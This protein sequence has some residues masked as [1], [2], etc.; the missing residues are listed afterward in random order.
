MK[1]F[2]K[3]I[4]VGIITWEAKVILAKY[5]PKT[6][7]VI[8]SVGKTTAKNAIHSA[9]SGSFFVRKT[10]KSIS[11]DMGVPLAVLGLRFGG[12]NPFRWT[13]NII[14][15]FFMI[16]IKVRYPQWLILEVGG[17]RPGDVSSIARWLSP[18][19]VVITRLGDI[20][21]HVEYFPSPE[22]LI[23]EKA[24][25][26][27]SLKPEGM[28]VLNR[29]DRRV[30]E[31][32]DSFINAKRT[33]GFADEAELKASHDAIVYGLY[34]NS[35]IEL[36]MGITF[37]VDYEGSSVPLTISGTLGRQ[38]IYAA[39]AALAVGTCHGIDLISLAQALSDHVPPKGRMRLLPGIKDSLIIDDTYNSSPVAVE[40][41]LHTLQMIQAPGRK[42]AILG[43]MMELGEYSIE[44]HRKVGEQAAKTVDL[45]VTVGV[46]SRATADAALD[47]GFSD[48]RI[49]QFDTPREA[50]KYLSEHLTQADIIFI[51]GSQ[52][53]RME[54]A[55]EEL[56]LN[57]ERKE[58]FLVRQESYWKISY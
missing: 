3:G 47:A 8:G 41:G 13:L 28:L 16:F 24:T 25:I 45:L 49:L 5:K 53:M 57:R 31:L 7:V 11:A 17:D 34:E 37:R 55:V 29:D 1:D 15:G 27:R 12:L 39:L 48:D 32:S 10:D 46:R 36:P 35:A 20:P 14:E 51:K 21:A 54:W 42:I 43:D 2:F 26:A 40:E 56:M 6:I 30:M 18:D 19:T 9:L 4:I 44:S 50:G 38:S 52:P 22:D 23:N 58:E 33:Y